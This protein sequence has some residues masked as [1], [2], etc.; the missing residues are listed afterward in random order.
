MPAH[1]Q[2]ILFCFVKEVRK[3]FPDLTVCSGC[4]FNTLS[5]SHHVGCNS[6]TLKAT[7]KSS[8]LEVSKTNIVLN[9]YQIHRALGLEIPDDAEIDLVMLKC[10]SEWKSLVADILVYGFGNFPESWLTCI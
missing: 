3:K 2:L 1:H 7:I 8:S 6:V 9:L 10:N 5:Q 4:Y